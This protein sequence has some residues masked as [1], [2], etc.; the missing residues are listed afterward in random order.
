MDQKK[1]LFIAPFPNGRF[2]GGITSI[3]KSLQSKES[4]DYLAEKSYSIHFFN[5]HQLKQSN[6]SIGKLKAENLVQYF[7]LITRL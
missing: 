6:N 7:S 1:V 4:L 2:E 3:A 5:S